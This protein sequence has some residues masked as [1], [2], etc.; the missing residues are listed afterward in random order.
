MNRLALA[1]MIPPLIAVTGCCDDPVGGDPPGSSPMRWAEAASLTGP[2]SAVARAGDAIYIAADGLALSTD[3]GASFSPLAAEG[4]PAGHVN[5]LVAFDAEPDVVVAYVWGK[6][7]YRSTDAGASF[8]ALDDLAT[9]DLLLSFVTARAKVVPFGSGSDR[10]DPTRAV[11][12]GPGGV[13]STSDSGASWALLEPDPSAQ[14]Y[15]L[16]TDAAVA[17]DNIVAIAQAPLTL[18]PPA[19][20]SVIG[21]GV[22]LSQDGGATWEDISADLPAVAWTSVAIDAEGRVAVGTMDGGAYLRDGDRNWQSLGGASDVIAVELSAGGVS[23]GSAS[24]GLW[25]HDGDTLSQ[26]GDG[27][28][29]ATTPGY[30]VM[31]D[32]RVFREVDGEGDEPPQPAGGTVHLALSFHVNLYHSF[33]GDTNDEEGYGLDIEVIRNSLDWLDAYPEVRADWDMENAFSTDDLLATEAPDILQ[34]VRA[35]VEAG[36]DDVR[37]MSWNNGAVSAQTFVEFEAS[38]ERAKTSLQTAFGSF[39]PGVQPQENMFAPDHVGWYRQLGIEW[40]TL[41]NSMSPFTGPPLDVPLEGAANYSPLTLMDGNDEMIFVPV[42]HH[43]DVFDHGGLSGW[44]QQISDSFEGDTLLVIHFD[45]DGETWLNF[46]GELEAIRDL[47]FVRYTTIQAYLDEH[48]P[49]ETIELLGDQADGIGDGYQSWA[50]K[51]IN[52]EIYTAVVRAR[53]TAD[54]ALAIGGTDPAVVTAVDAALTPRLLTLSTTNFGLAAP[55]LHPDREITA[56]DFAAQSVAMADAALQLA[57]TPLAPG[58]IEL[59]NTR[60]SAGPALIEVDVSLAQAMFVDETGLVIRDAGVELPAIVEVIDAGDPVTLRAT[61]VTD[62]PASGSKVLSWTYDP[63]MPATVTGGAHGRR[64]RC[65][66]FRRSA[67]PPVQ[68]VPRQRSERWHGV[69]R[70][71][72]GSRRTHG[73]RERIGGHFAHVVRRHGRVDAH[74]ACV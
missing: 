37:L 2:A 25:R 60:P 41:F 72:P 1:L 69:G 70:K 33:R 14:F 38:V 26:L 42:Y 18:L 66:P 52:H 24:R 29:A 44:M 51:D 21:S 32:G 49:S 65:L 5:A 6:G 73:P 13:Y 57:L 47:P 9:Y 12:A 55:F 56:R 71:R 16:F 53:D 17:G 7:L 67:G 40:I 10:D 43:A 45:A 61:L 58:Q 23:F 22:V 3:E 28:V 63:M 31:H 50:E 11:L 62:V 46:D 30:A 20:A 74:A 15:A 36:S 48:P 39:V 27:P 64:S 54:A 19:V 4:L 59:T 68:R 34:R 35:R 8:D